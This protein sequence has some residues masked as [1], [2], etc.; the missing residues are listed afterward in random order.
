[1]KYSFT[2]TRYGGCDNTYI[3]IHTLNFDRVHITNNTIY[4]IILKFKPKA[5]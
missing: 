1:M 4:N 3:N 2:N 5:N